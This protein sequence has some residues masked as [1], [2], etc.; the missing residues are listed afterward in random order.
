[1]RAVLASHGQLKDIE[2][3]KPSPGPHDLL[4]EV[5]AVSV[6]PVDTKVLARAKDTGDD[7]ILGFDAVGTV[8]DMGA[9]VKGFKAGDRVW[10]AGD[11][12]RPGSNADYQCVDA[13]IVSIAPQSLNDAEA[14]AL[15]LTSLTAWELLFDRM[16]CPA[17]Y[18]DR[19]ILVI[20]GAGG[21]GSILIQLAK[22]LT[23]ATVVATASRDESKAWVKSLGADYV[24]DHSEPL[25]AGL[26]AAGLAD[27]TDVVSL[28]HTEVHF[29]D[30]M[31]IIRPQGRFALIDD[32]ATPLDISAMKQKSL[33]LH[34][35]FMFTRTMFKTEDMR[36]QGEILAQVASLIDDGQL[37]TSLSKTLSP[38]N[39]ETLTEAHQLVLSQHMTGKVVVSR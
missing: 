2:T 38:I 31:Q 22:K 5:N 14:A 33:S 13:R 24:I 18:D 9:E 28:T 11:V 39:A 34:W 12:T 23:K 20:G 8:V 35:E 19:V 36:R 21:V 15:P 37:R 30:V 32:P 7:K 6:N 17:V 1:M 29:D 16:H 4:V 10:Y 26:A 27:V 3:D 25:S